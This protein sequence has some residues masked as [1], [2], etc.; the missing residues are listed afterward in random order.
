MSA[1][2]YY[3]W[4]SRPV[5]GRESDNQRLFSGGLQKWV[6]DITEVRTGEGKLFLCV[7]LDL[8]SKLV[9]GWPMHH[10]QD[11]QMVI[12]AVEM[13]FCSAKVVGQ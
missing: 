12:R 7:V 2:G 1:S 11:R 6:T 9:V 3:S 5:N 13:A 8:F 4:L 10:L